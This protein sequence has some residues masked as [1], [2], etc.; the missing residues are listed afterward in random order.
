MHAAGHVYNLLSPAEETTIHHGVLRILA[1][2]GMQVSILI[3]NAPASL[4]LWSN[5]FWLKPKNRIGK[6]AN[7]G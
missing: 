5:G 7:P 3:D 1:E 6:P 4:L 2:V